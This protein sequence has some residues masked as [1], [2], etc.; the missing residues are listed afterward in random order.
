MDSTVASEPV[1]GE[2]GAG[3]VVEWQEGEVVEWFAPWTCGLCE[4]RNEFEQGHQQF[5][6]VCCQRDRTVEYK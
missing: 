4:K 6:C 1:L 2:G 3:E 5:F